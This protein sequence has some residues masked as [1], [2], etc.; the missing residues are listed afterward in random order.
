VM[1]QSLCGLNVPTRSACAKNSR[2]N[3]KDFA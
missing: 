3:G 1:S 2:A